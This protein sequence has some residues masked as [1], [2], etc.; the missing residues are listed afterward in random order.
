MDIKKEDNHI[1]PID[2]A[3]ILYACAHADIE[4][5]NKRIYIENKFICSIDSY[6]RHIPIPNQKGLYKQYASS[7]PE[8]INKECTSIVPQEDIPHRSQ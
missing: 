8:D 2:Y 1:K 4:S 5:Y 6:K 7:I 3:R